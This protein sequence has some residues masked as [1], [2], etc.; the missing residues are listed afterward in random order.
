M[1]EATYS[2]GQA[3]KLLGTSSY[4]IRRLCE[5]SL[6]DAGLSE[7]NRWRIPASEVERLKGEGL[8]PIPQSIEEPPAAARAIAPAI[9]PAAPETRRPRQVENPAPPAESDSVR[10]ERDEL[11]IAET[12]LKRRR[13]ELEREEVEDQFRDRQRKT[14]QTAAAERRQLE[15]Q[16][17]AQ[18]RREWESSWIQQALGAIPD[19]APQESRIEVYQKT[20][21]VLESLDSQ[22]APDI[23]RRVVEAVVYQALQPHF[24]ARRRTHAITEGIA[25]IPTAL[26]A[27][28]AKAKRAAEA[29]VA[30]LPANA[31]LEDLQE[32]VG[33]AVGPIIAEIQHQKAKAEVLN[34]MRMWGWLD[35][36]PDEQEQ[37]REAVAAALDSVP[38]GG[39]LHAAKAAALVPIE[40]AIKKRTAEKHRKETAAQVADSALWHINAYLRDN[41][42]DVELTERW[43]EES[44]LKAELRPVLIA[45]I[46]D[47]LTPGD[48]EDFVHEWLGENVAWEEEDD[49][50]PDYEEDEDDEED[51]DE[52]D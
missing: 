1:T 6:I 39:D 21:A 28:R 49:D 41:F 3:A 16:Q 27:H 18:R 12:Q 24:Q 11:T 38:A 2:T 35:A 13:V 44:R 48:V 22:Q 19:D 9:E 7:G 34:S 45:E 52:E 36:T 14:V 26:T 20:K 17:A 40:K 51:D 47:G 29:A 10:D 42:P 4:H 8:P 43:E 23:T 37:A 31:A 33:V 32:A 5:S 30:K 15:Q 46:L 50:E 25:A